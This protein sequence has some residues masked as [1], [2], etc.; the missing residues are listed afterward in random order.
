MRR[1]LTMRKVL[2]PTLF[3]FVVTAFAL[4]Q[5]AAPTEKSHDMGGMDMSGHDMSSMG[6]EAHAMHFMED[7]HMDMGPHMK[8]TALRTFKPGTRRKP[9]KLLPAR[10]K[11][12]RNIKTTKSRW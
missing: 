10:A 2:F 7:R 3:L 11:L 4:A 9:I 5:D 6:G 8:M 1:R 12:R